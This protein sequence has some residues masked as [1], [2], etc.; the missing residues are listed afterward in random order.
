MK[1][2]VALIIAVFLLLG[3]TGGAAQTKVTEANNS[4]D[5]QAGSIQNQINTANGATQNLSG[6][7]NNAVSNQT[8]TTNGSMAQTNNSSDSNQAQTTNGSG[9]QPQGSPF[10]NPVTP[11]PTQNTTGVM[12]ADYTPPPMPQFDFTNKTNADGNLIVY[13]FYLPHCSA[14]LTIKPDMD[15]L[16]TEFPQAVWQE[17]DIST[18]TG[19]WAY[20]NFS[21]QMSLNASQ[22]YVPQVL[23]DGVVITTWPTINDT[24]KGNISA[25]YSDKNKSGGSG[26][27]A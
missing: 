10:S 3:C 2:L 23:V 7:T 14:C 16:K 1:G 24:L 19:R 12:M 17:Y 11:P 5:S 6:S 9:V 8:Q 13:Y 27:P 4:A 26:G 15:K 21:A 18:Q 22:I 20:D 25:F